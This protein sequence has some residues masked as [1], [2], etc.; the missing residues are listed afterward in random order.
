MT[1]YK[2][3]YHEDYSGPKKTTRDCRQRVLNRRSTPSIASRHVPPLTDP[4]AP[5]IIQIDQFIA[6]QLALGA[7][8]PSLMAKKKFFAR[9][10][11]PNDNKQ[12]NQ[13]RRARERTQ[14][15]ANEAP[16]KSAKKE[17]I[18]VTN[19]TQVRRNQADVRE[20][21]R[22]TG[23]TLRG[24]RNSGWGFGMR[25]GERECK[26]RRKQMGTGGFAL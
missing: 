3:I 19:A 1:H 10:P 21:R 12:K 9:R 7:R 15:I 16:M 2:Y 4:R 14:I 24:K 13:A 17:P 26:R 22:I 25:C 23:D 20:Y 5:T 6:E 18:A 11:K 8:S